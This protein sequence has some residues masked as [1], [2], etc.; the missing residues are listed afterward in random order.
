[1]S[2]HE[3]SIRMATHSDVPS[4]I[5]LLADDELGSLREKYEKPIPKSITLL[6]N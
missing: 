6:M 2:A 4:I 1:M 3:I 5:R